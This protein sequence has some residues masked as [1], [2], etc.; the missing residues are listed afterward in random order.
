MTKFYV[1]FPL[2]RIWNQSQ[3]K[4]RTFYLARYVRPPDQHRFCL[5]I[6]IKI[7]I[8][9]QILV[10]DPT[11]FAMCRRWS[12][13]PRG[14]QRFRYGQSWFCWWRC[15][16]CSVS[17][18]RWASSNELDTSETGRFSSLRMGSTTTI[19]GFPFGL[20]WWW[21]LLSESKN[22]HHHRFRTGLNEGVYGWHGQ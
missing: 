11:R 7:T 22:D 12:P 15:S 4:R 14:R 13:G 8:S 9:R 6:K 16:T 5:K 2:N 20:R 10:I 18:H 1:F 19:I 21:W 17:V 3:A